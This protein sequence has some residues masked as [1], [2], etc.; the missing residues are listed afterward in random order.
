MRF[1]NIQECD[2]HR[3]D[4]VV[5][6]SGFAGAV[7]ARQI[8]DAAN[9]KVLILEKRNHIGGNMYD[10]ENDFGVNVHW[11]GPHL[12]HTNSKEVY[13][14][15]SRFTGWYDYRH[16]VVGSIGGK[17]VPIPFNFKS[18]DMLFDENTSATYKE[19]I[20]RFFPGVSKASVM[21]LINHQD[22][23]I[24]KIGYYV[25]EN[26]FVNYTSKQWGIH[27]DNIDKSVIN[28]VPV[29]FGYQDGYFSDTYQCMPGRGYMPI[30]KKM[31]ES[32]NI[33]AVL[34]VDANEYISIGENEVEVLGTAA[35][36]PIIYTGMIDALCRYRYGA[37]PYRSLNMVFENHEVDQY[38]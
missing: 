26:V 6:G 24:R 28:R 21:D 7:I 38:Q 17:I 9:I 36:I 29:V 30:F 12:F 35:A 14:Y 13:D 18:I 37:L 33:S 34:G 31:L 5:V 22:E 16:K 15:L 10:G 11:Y 8:S 2:I 4:A 32:D 1:I 25:Y 23:D 3:F 19:K 27:P 20:S